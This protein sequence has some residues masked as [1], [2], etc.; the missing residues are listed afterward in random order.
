M[1]VNLATFWTQIPKSV[2]LM[3]VWYQIVKHARLTVQSAKFAT[4][5]SGLPRR[6][7]ALMQPV[8]FLTAINVI[9]KVPTHVTNAK[10][11]TL[12][13]LAASVKAQFATFSASS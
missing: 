1:F 11:I 13:F 6:M 8:K 12:L 10:Q 3:D 2:F 4:R 9:S 5:I 7:N